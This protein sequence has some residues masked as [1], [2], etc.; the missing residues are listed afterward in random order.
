M[1]ELKKLNVGNI[2]E[3][4]LLQTEQ[5]NDESEKRVKEP[6]YGS[7]EACFYNCLAYAAKKFG[8]KCSPGKFADDYYD[9]SMYNSIYGNNKKWSGTGCKTE[10]KEGP[11][12]GIPSGISYIP[13]PVAYNYIENYFTTTGG[14]WKRKEDEVKKLM[15]PGISGYVMGVIQTR[16]SNGCLSLSLSAN[17]HAVILQYISP[18]GEYH[19]YDP[20][21]GE[22]K[23]C[24][25]SDVLYAGKMTGVKEEVLEKKKK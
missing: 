11:N 24:I 4:Q 8:W 6:I 18:S 21:N 9:G 1:K 22:Y 25:P 23:S 2:D 14:G 20:T 17:K 13:N 5:D 7:D 3:P 15:E 10:S 19:Y 16:D 12:V